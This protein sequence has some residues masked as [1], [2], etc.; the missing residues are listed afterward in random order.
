[1]LSIGKETAVQALGGSIF[2]AIRRLKKPESWDE[3]PRFIAYAHNFP[4]FPFSLYRQKVTA[5]KTIAEIHNVAYGPLPDVINAVTIFFQIKAHNTHNT[6][7]IYSYSGMTLVIHCMVNFRHVSFREVVDSVLIDR[8]RIDILI[9]SL[10]RQSRYSTK[11]S[12][13]SLSRTEKW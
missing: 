8:S 11:N 2:W 13:D 7:P 3:G 1:M 5:V 12:L 4:S 6:I 10:G 9:H